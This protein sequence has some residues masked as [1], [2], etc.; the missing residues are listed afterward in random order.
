M[1]RGKRVL[2]VEDDEVNQMLIQFMISDQEGEMVL[3]PNKDKALDLLQSSRFDLLLLDTRLDNTNALQFTRH[4]RNVLHHNI[5]IIGL[6]SIN[7]Q[8]RGLYSGLDA[9]IRRPLEYDKFLETLRE[10]MSVSV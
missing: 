4:L 5:P 1:L 2:L 6:T 3:E 7:L 9:V 10:V 8:G